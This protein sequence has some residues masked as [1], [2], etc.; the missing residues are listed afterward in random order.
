M[1][2]LLRRRTPKIM[3]HCSLILSTFVSVAAFSA[4]AQEACQVDVHSFMPKNVAEGQIQVNSEAAQIIRNK[5][6]T[7]E[8]SVTIA[9]SESTIKTESATVEENGKIIRADGD[10]L[11]TD[12]LLQVD[13]VGVEVNAP[14]KL[15][16]MASTEY[17]LSTTK[18]RGGAELLSIS[19]EKGVLLED[20]SFTTCPVGGEDWKIQASEM[21]IKKGRP[22]GEAKH[23][24]FY[25]G[26]IPIFYLPYFAFPI[27]TERQSGFLFPD[28]G[29]SSS[30]G[31]EYEQPFYWNIAP[32][33]DTTFSTRFMTNRGV[34][35]KNEFRYLFAQ[36]AGELHVEYLPSD[37]D[38]DQDKSRYFYRFTHRGKLSD[39]WSVVA[40]I[41]DLSDDNYI[42][43]LG[44]DFYNQ[45]DTHLYRQLGVSYFSQDL[46]FSMSIRDFAT[47]GQVDSNYRALPEA[48]LNYS[49]SLTNNL[50]FDVK[51]ELAYFENSN[52]S[53]ANAVRFH[54]EPSLTLPYQK[55]WGEFLAQISVLH[56]YYEQDVP[57]GNNELAETVDRTLGQARLYGSLIF[58]RPNVGIKKDYTMTFEPRMQYLYTSF[59]EQSS[60]GL[61][62]TTELLTTFSNLFRGQEFTGLDR[63]NDN[64]QFTLGA[65]TR[66]IDSNNREVLVA[67]VGQ[68]IYL[69][70]SKLQD[71]IRSD[72]RSAIAAELDWE[73]NQNWFL[74][75]DI[76]VSDA[77]DKVERSSFSTEYRWSDEKL[78][79]LNHRYIRSL[80]NEQIDQFGI[81]ASWPINKKWHWVGR[82]YRDIER[83]RT[84]ESFFG[85]EYESC[86][87]ALRLTAQRRLA[88]R[89]NN[90][91]VRDLN[92]FDSSIGLQFVFKG[93]GNNNR[94]R[95][96]IGMLEQ[97][98]FGYRQPFVLN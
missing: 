36:H 55:S 26:G 14:L 28:I 47:L 44:S 49:T 83:S 93:L 32:N 38:R 59:E 24:V 37:L 13:S 56:T 41:S 45:A 72:N 79:Q 10:V 5:V 22:F 64:N 23:T 81:S 92:E 33:L 94:R 9:T 78:V 77:T 48:K 88:T 54:I 63:I 75:S 82:W 95:N 18:G 6:A 76:Q 4:S 42:V 53:L 52:S 91:G 86:C 16:Q 61:Y 1:I 25:V 40:D 8:G 2:T 98:L 85:I 51:S 62:D 17:K 60:I 46:D 73:V 15:L 69:E 74:H 97:G 39:N 57:N 90:D 19:Q 58:E 12:A 3:K 50:N 27:T 67:S 70:N 66:F 29:S 71:S 34:Q 21:S 35:F 87:W 31:V 89:F 96:K 84:S 80:S 7:F 30:T 11:Y 68:I 65:T 43:D 20:V